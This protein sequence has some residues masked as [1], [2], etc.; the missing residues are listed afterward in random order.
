MYSPAH[1]P[2]ILRQFSQN[3]FLVEEL[4]LVSVFEVFRYLV[5]SLPRQ[6]P[7]RHV[8]LHLLQLQAQ[9]AVSGAAGFSGYRYQEQTENGIRSQI[10]EAE[11][12]L[13]S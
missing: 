10:F 11:I 5:A 8:L 2:E 9:L 3:R 13:F 4:A 1:L 12:N 6:L 7:V